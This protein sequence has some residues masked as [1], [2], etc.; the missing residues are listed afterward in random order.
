[1]TTE[2]KRWLDHPRN[3]DR[4]FYWLCGVCVLVFVADFFF[5]KHGYFTWEHWVGFHGVYGFIS[6]VGLVL[7][8]K[9]MRRLVKRPED[10]YDR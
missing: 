9:Q 6:C 5:E 7:A 3:V 8:A 2:R 4:I 1:M 10:Y